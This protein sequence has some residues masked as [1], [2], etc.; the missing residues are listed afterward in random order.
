MLWL[1]LGLLIIPAIE[2]GVFIWVGSYIGA[3]WVVMLI[4]ITGIAGL[5]LARY[6]GM[7]TI[8]KAQMS[9][10]SGQMP[11]P[12]LIEGF[13]ILAGGIMLFAPGFVTDTIGLFLIIP[14]TRKLAYGYIFNFLRKR[15]NKGTFIFRR[16]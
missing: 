3:F 1:L 7:R 9:M 15:M 10:V 16:F 14:I 6:E 2:I 8:Q 5:A 4:I 13:C 11:G 12:Q